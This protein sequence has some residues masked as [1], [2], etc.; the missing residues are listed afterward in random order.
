MWKAPQSIREML[1]RNVNDFP[2]R[3][4]LVSPTYIDGLWSYK[5]WK[6]LDLI[7]DHIAAGLE[8]I[9]L[10]KGQKIAF[11]QN[12]CIECVYAYLAAHKIGAMFVPI[13]TRFVTREIEFIIENSDAEHLIVGGEFATIAQKI[14][15]ENSRINTLICI[16]K[17]GEKVPDRAISFNDLMD[18]KGTPSEVSILAEDEADLIYTSGTTGRPKGVILT[19]ANKVAN[20]RLSSASLDQWRWHNKCD[21]L[22]SSFPFFTSAGISTTT[23]GWLYYGYCLIMEERFDVL[24]TLETIDREKTT[25]YAAA[26]SMLLFIMDHPRFKDFDTSSIKSIIA[27][28][29]AIAREVIVRVLDIWPKAKIYNFYGLTEAGPGGSCLRIE[30]TDLS[31]ADSIGLPWA[32]DQ[33]IRVVDDQDRDVET[34]EVGEIVIRGPNVMKGYYKNPSATDEAL[35]NGWLHSGDMGCFDEDRYLYY[36]DRMKD[37][38]NRGGYNVYPA[39][40]ESV[41]YEHQNVK[42][43]AVIGKPHK[44]LGEDLVAYVIPK[45]D[46]KLTTEEITRFCAERMADFKCPRDIRFVESLPLNAMGKLDKVKLREL[47]N[48]IS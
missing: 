22:Q 2:N 28:G 32:S 39:E 46:K 30:K 1:E 12:N 41:L 27:G 37:M 14:K 34:D 29:S 33:E 38:I 44:K 8:R 31:K 21:I 16:C 17:D 18:E 15:D 23:M 48:E 40:V 45:E 5:T 9:G 6:E 11:I 24:K 42:Q 10:K 3:D 35:R 26:P 4:A 7:T 36:K 19:E 13:N 20:G 47:C 25:I 43:C